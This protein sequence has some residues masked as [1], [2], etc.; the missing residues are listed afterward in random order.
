MYVQYDLLLQFQSI[1]I[2]N[3]IKKEMLIF[4]DCHCVDSNKSLWDL[5]VFRLTL[6]SEE[7][8]G[9][10]IEY[11]NIWP[12]YLIFLLY[13]YS[14]RSWYLDYH[15]CQKKG[16]FFIQQKVRNFCEDGN[17]CDSY[18]DIWIIVK[19]ALTI[20]LFFSYF[21]YLQKRNKK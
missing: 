12:S 9:D 3:F 1:S 21:S 20:F 7:K 10:E 11:F 2:S 6:L 13:F 14:F 17:L 5:L 18:K 8:K 4:I 15:S 19:K 16:R